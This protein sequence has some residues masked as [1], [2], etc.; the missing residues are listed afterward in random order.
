MIERLSREQ[1]MSP[2]EWLYHHARYAFACGHV[3]GR[4]VLDIACGT[5]YGSE[6]LA[7]Y[8]ARSVTG[9]DISPEALEEARRLHAIGGVTF[10]E[11][12]ALDPPVAGPFGAAVSLETIEHVPDPEGML[13]RIVERLTPDGVFVCSSP[14]RD[15]T[16]PGST[17]HDRPANPF[18]LVEL[19]RSE[20]DAALRARF[21]EVRLYGQLFQL[22]RGVGLHRFAEALE[23]ATAWPTRLPLRP[24]YVVA[25]CR[26]PRS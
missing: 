26:R 4:D 14:N 8:G 1:G 7:Q 2:L 10:V 19:S 9:V 21:H 17:R 15:V 22:P 24:L 3:L 12:D 18:H 5:G 16:R 6:L 11:G 13:D 20:F 25:V 23:R